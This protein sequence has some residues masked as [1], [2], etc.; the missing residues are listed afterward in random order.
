MA[1][2]KKAE[3]DKQLEIAVRA[4][5]YYANPEHWN[6]DDWGVQAVIEEY[7]EAG[8]HARKALRRMGQ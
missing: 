3:L 1:V 7:G 4:L 5:R 8:E 6:A 2:Q